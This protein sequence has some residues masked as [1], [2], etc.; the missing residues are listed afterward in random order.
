[1]NKFKYIAEDFTPHSVVY[2]SYSKYKRRWFIIKIENKEFLYWNR[3]SQQWDIKDD[4]ASCYFSE[5]TTKQKAIEICTLQ[6]LTFFGKLDH[7]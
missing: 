4:Y 7:E 6:S 1:M 2:I 5:A 3:N